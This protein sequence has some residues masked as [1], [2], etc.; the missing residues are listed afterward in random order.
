MLSHGILLTVMSDI[1]GQARELVGTIV[2]ETSRKLPPRMEAIDAA[3]DILNTLV[4]RDM[5]DEMVLSEVGEI[6]MHLRDVA[7]SR[8]Q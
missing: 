5:Y 7:T 8:T 2:G 1:A 3:L 6:L 4:P